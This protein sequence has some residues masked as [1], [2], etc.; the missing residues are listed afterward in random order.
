MP[1]GAPIQGRRRFGAF[2]EE[3]DLFPYL[4]QVMFMQRH[5]NDSRSEGQI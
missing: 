5:L 3:V 4:K 2:L 1:P